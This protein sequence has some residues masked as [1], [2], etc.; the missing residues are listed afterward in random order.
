MKR[1]RRR[2]PDPKRRIDDSPILMGGL[3]VRKCDDWILELTSL[4]GDPRYGN[5]APRLME[6][7][8]ELLVLKSTIQ[9][10]I[11]MAKPG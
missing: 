10:L 3:F 11:R 7:R 8:S 4:L 5:E 6:R 1:I 9:E 2:A